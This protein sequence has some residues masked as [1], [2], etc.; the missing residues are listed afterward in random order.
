MTTTLVVLAAKMG[1]KYGGLKQLEGIGP[2]GETILDYSMY[3]AVNAGFNKVVFVISKYFEE[4]FKEK[5]SSRYEGKIKIEYAF[6]EVE[7][8]PDEIR[9]AK[10]TLL[11]GSAHAML[12]A[13]ELINEP[14]GV[15][16]ATNFYQRE[17]FELLFNNLQK[18]RN[19]SGH[20]FMISFRLANVLAESGGVTR[21][22]CEVD[23]N[24]ELVSIVDRVGVERIGGDPMFLNEY[25]KWEQLDEN[26]SIS[27]N[28]WGF[29]P[30]IFKSVTRSFNAFIIQRGADLKAELSI[31]HFINEMVQNGMK[32][33]TINTPAKWMGLV[34]ADDRI[35]VILRINDL[36][37]KGAYPKKIFEITNLQNT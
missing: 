6:Q 28:M 29:T 25:N 22:I 4:E 8:V 36:I 23:E 1:N 7:S 21:G 5:I 14:F 9:N 31:P 32:V 13:K 3:D 20:H 2:N 26:A 18:I 12:M 10:R 30:D 24:G 11:W 37:R 27:M 16:N 33:K 34:S 15:I 19:T 35:Q 17:S